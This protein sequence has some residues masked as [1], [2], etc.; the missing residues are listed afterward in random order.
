MIA[1]KYI[2]STVTIVLKEPMKNV[3]PVIYRG[4][5][6]DFSWSVRWREEEIRRRAEEKQKEIALKSSA[7]GK[8]MGKEISFSRK[9]TKTGKLYAA[10]SEKN[11]S[12]AIKEQLSVE[13]PESAITIAEQIKATGTFEVKVKIGEHEQGLKV[14]VKVEE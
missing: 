7:I 10:L 1:A 5:R 3:A 14:I 4:Q 13:V 12:A 2:V 8:I 6:S 9:T 11:L